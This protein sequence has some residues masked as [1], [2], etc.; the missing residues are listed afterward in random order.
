MSA[1][2]KA[3]GTDAVSATASATP[4]AQHLAQHS[5]AWRFVVLRFI[6]RI[7]RP[8]RHAQPLA[9]AGPVRSPSS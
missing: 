2:A 8:A 1:V 5:S 4:V 7:R 3:T 9:D 6:N